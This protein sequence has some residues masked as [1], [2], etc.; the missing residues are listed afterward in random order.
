MKHMSK[1]TIISI[2]AVVLG[3]LGFTGL[4]LAANNFTISLPS[5]TTYEPGETFTANISI[6]PSEKVYT[7]GIQ[8]E[9]PVNLLRIE[10]FN[11]AS[12]WMPLSQEG[13]DN[14]DNTNGLLIKT[15]GYPGGI[16]SF[17]TIG[18][19]TFKTLNS[20]QATIQLTSDTFAL[21]AQN[22]NVIDSLSSVQ[23]NIRASEIIP[24]EQEEEEA[25]PDEEEEVVSDEE[26]EVVSEEEEKI[27]PEVEEEV[28]LEEEVI[29]PKEEVTTLH[30]E[31]KI[32][33]ENLISLLLASLEIMQESVWITIV[34]ILC[35]LGL[36]VIGIKE[37]ELLRKRKKE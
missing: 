21:N 24:G 13:Y 18:T 7:V 27:I 31:E 37:W 9:Y 14:I 6:S 22:A 5:G 16:I 23:I 11:F 8:L 10:S 4:I 28:T 17:K 3:T 32:P 36:V 15:A 26:E 20:G 25:V 12:T 30:P 34:V 2:I 35:L 33:E 1:K 29:L 19:V